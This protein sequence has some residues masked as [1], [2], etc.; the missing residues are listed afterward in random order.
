MRGPSSEWD[1]CLRFHFRAKHER[2]APKRKVS[3]AECTALKTDE[4]RRITS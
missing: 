4:T 3:R 2:N 1:D